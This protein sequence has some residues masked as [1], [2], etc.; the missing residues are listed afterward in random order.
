MFVRASSVLLVLSVI[1]YAVFGSPVDKVQDAGKRVGQGVNRNGSCPP[2]SRCYIDY[3]SPPCSPGKLCSM[4]MQEV[5][6]CAWGCGVDRLPSQCTQR[7]K[8]CKAEVCTDVCEC[9]I[10]CPA[11]GPCKAKKA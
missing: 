6:A 10:V 7:C 11:D 8:P 1:P 3:V 9:E 5:V 4:V 2:P